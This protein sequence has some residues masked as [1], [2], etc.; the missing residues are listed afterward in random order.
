MKIGIG[1]RL[2]SGAN[3]DAYSSSRKR[4][5]IVAALLALV[6][7][8]CTL[9]PTVR[10]AEARSGEPGQLAA[11]TGLSSRG[12][13]IYHEGEKGA[14]IYAADFLLLRDRLN[15]IPDTVFEPAC[16]THTHRWEYLHINGETHTRHC[17]FCGEA[18][19]LVDKHR[20]ERRESCM[21]SYQGAEYPGIRYTCVC[22]YQ[23]EREEAHTLLFE[24]VDETCHRSRCCLEGTPFCMGYEPVTEEHYAFHYIPCEDGRHHE[25]ICMDCGYRDEEECSFSLSDADSGEGDDSGGDETDSEENGGETGSENVGGDDGSSV[26]RCWC[27]NI[28]KSDTGVESEE[29]VSGMENGDKNSVTDTEENNPDMEIADEREGAE[30]GEENSDTEPEKIE[31]SGDETGERNADAE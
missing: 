12:S 23:W 8:S 9:T 6:L 4:C 22:G 2:K 25:R 11:W 10:A 16:Y 18:Y 1:N 3:K 15:T 21:L 27:G 30:T 20:A 13:L 17:E 5:G 19:D 29:D 7:G 28:E 31:T 14:Q 24:T 26:R